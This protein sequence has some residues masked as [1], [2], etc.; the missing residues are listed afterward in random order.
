M[1]AL[2]ILQTSCSDNIVRM[3]RNTGRVSCMSKRKKKNKNHPE[4]ILSAPQGCHLLLNLPRRCPFN[5]CPSSLTWWIRSPSHFIYSPAAAYKT[6]FLI[7]SASWVSNCHLPVMKINVA[8]LI[9]MGDRY[10]SA[11]WIYRL[12]PTV[13]NDIPS[14]VH[15]YDAHSLAVCFRGTWPRMRILTFFFIYRNCMCFQTKGHLLYEAMQIHVMWLERNQMCGFEIELQHTGM[16]KTVLKIFK[17]F[18]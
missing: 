4:Q 12:R 14:W 17:P 6:G 15:T 10:S 1:F 18:V 16:R 3:R 13:K 7:N 11:T 8:C 2:W 5:I 9:W